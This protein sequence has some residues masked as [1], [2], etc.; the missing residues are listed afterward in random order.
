MITLVGFLFVWVPHLLIILT[1][2]SLEDPPNRFFIFLFTIGVVVYST[3]DNMDGK[4]AR[5]TKTSSP[6]GMIFDHGLDAVNIFVQCLTVCR[7]LMFGPFMTGFALVISTMN[8]YANTYEQYLTHELVLP[9]INGPNEGIYANALCCLFTTIVG[10][11]F[12][13]NTTFLYMPLNFFLF[14]VSAGFVIFGITMNIYN[15][16]KEQKLEIFHKHSAFIYLIYAL[17]LL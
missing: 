13:V 5:K 8:F 3:L 15:I 4:Q 17:I 2:S 1:T 7:I 10:P 11:T 9:V 14:L 16:Q 6:L 12:W